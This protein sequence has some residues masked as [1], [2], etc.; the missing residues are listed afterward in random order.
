MNYKLMIPSLLS[1]LRLLL[2]LIFPFVPSSWWIWLIVGGG[3]SDFFDGQLARRWHV[4]TWQGGLLDAIAD[5][6]FVNKRFV[7]SV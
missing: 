6:L 4:Q 1:G 5:K 7:L 3:A 2:A